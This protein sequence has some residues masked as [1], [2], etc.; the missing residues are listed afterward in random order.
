MARAKETFKH[1]KNGPVGL[2]RN[3]QA[4]LVITSD[5][6]KHGSD[7][8]FVSSY[9]CYLLAFIGI[10]DLTIID[11]SELNREEENSINKVRQEIDALLLLS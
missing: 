9:L 2:L 5:R 7:I 4:I 6:T 11:E 8:D 10:N 1:T 3:K